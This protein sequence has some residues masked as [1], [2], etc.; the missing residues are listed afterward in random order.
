MNTIETTWPP[1]Y[2]VR[3]SKRAKRINL[4]ITPYKGLE[5]VI[6]NN[7]N[8]EDIHEVL[9]QHRPW[10]IKHLQTVAHTLV[11]Q[12]QLHKP[13]L[14]ELRALAETWQVDY[15]EICARQRILPRPQQ[16]LV[17]MYQQQSKPTELLK[18]WLKRYAKNTL[19]PWIDDISE[20]IGL[21][22]SR[23]SIRGQKLRWGSCSYRGNIS[24]N[25]KLLFLPT[26]LVTHTIIHELCH[27][28]HLNH[29]DRFWRLVAKHDPH[30]RQHR[31]HLSQA[32]QYIP[33]WAE[34]S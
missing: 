18:F 24:L 6:P 27:T 10:I 2:L 31:K 13:K 34:V 28:K 17:C 12:E 26:E 8:H 20:D 21:D 11:D 16:Q 33:A 19:Q 14:L 7:A 1:Q 22:Y 9:E 23:L 32:A 30:W 29:S 15:R 3:E 5:V 25:Y 4:Y